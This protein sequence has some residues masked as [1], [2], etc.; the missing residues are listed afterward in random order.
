MHTLRAQLQLF[1]GIERETVSGTEKL[2]S[3]LGGVLSIILVVSIA[4]YILGNTGAVLIIPSM[5]ASAVLLFAVPHGRLAPPCAV[6]GGQLVSAIVG[7]TGYQLVPDP[8]LAAG[9][10]VGLAIGA[11]HLLSCIHPPGG[12]TALAAVIGGP[13]IHALGY[14]YIF[15]P[16]LLNVTVMLTVAMFFNSVFPWRRY[17]ASMMRFTDMPGTGRSRVARLLDKHNIEQALEDMDLIVDISTEELQRLFAL[18]LEHAE[19]QHVTPSQL[20]LGHYYTNGKHGAD[21]SVRRIIDEPITPGSE[22]HMVTYRVVEGRGARSTNTCPR[23]EFAQWAARRVFPN[24]AP[25]QAESDKQAQ[26]L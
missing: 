7:V 8:F 26:Q 23:V 25:V 17:P 11:M 19:K 1:L 2:V 13:A 16:T 5:G 6:C 22:K 21:W 3:T 14:Y 20:R 9:L 24:Q 10:A 15:M 12:A 4:Y 18:T